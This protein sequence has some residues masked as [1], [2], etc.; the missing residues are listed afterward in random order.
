MYENGKNILIF[1]ATYNEA[2][3]IIA[4]IT[5][6]FIY[7]PQAHILV[8]D[9]NSP[10]GTSQILE[11]YKKS[12][13]SFS[14]HIQIITRSRKL[15]LGS[16][17]QIGFRYAIEQDYKA[18]ITMDADFSHNPKYLPIFTQKLERSDFIIGSRFTGDGRSNYGVIR[19][20]LSKTAN[21]LVRSLL[22][23]QITETTTSYRGFTTQL[24]K[25]LNLGSIKSEGYSF[26]FECVNRVCSTTEK[27]E[28]IPIHF[29]DRRA[30]RSKISKKEIFFSIL[31][32]LRLFYENLIKKSTP[33]TPTE[34]EC[35]CKNCESSFFRQ[36]FPEKVTFEEQKNEVWMGKSH[37]SH[38][39]IIKCLTCGLIQAKPKLQSKQILDFYHN[40]KDPIYIENAHSRLLT[41]R[42]NL[43]KLKN[44]LPRRGK[45]LEVGSHCGIF[46]KMI[47]EEG[48][49]AVGLEPSKWANKYATQDLRVHSINGS[50]QTLPAS[51]NNFDIV[52]S[53]DVLEHMPNPLDELK[54]IN[55]RLKPEGRLAFSTINFDSWLPKILGEHWPW[56]MDMHLFYFSKDVLREML[57]KAG[58]QIVYNSSYRRIINFKYFLERLD[59]LG[60]IG[61][62]TAVNFVEKTPL[63]NINIPFQFGDFQSYVCVKTRDI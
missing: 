14:S 63:K 39:Q 41:F 31:T 43:N 5:K 10:D 44:H 2:D 7:V 56:L 57:D 16:A 47:Q 8:V 50:L 61:T 21:I 59:S 13:D 36:V 32:L 22:K 40:A 24:L 53:W 48:Y 3:N 54:L 46:L 45:L 18:I 34:Y 29:E 30:G 33:N 58:F 28:E 51:Y 19:K 25:S 35:E 15:G 23:I 6:I 4:L 27:I 55:Q 62:K 42:H 11:K 37:K 1:L 17:H 49:E 9:D 52:I 20:T 12:N 60:F 38:G 26:F